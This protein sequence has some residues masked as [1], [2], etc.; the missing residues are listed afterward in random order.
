ML[1]EKSS[2]CKP[3]TVFYANAICK[4][5]SK[6]AQSHDKVELIL[7]QGARIQR[8]REAVKTFSG[9]VSVCAHLCPSL[10]GAS[11]HELAIKSNLSA[12]KPD[13]A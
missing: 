10:G 4:L 11:L 7:T 13:V 1:T 3:R 6:T 9:K 5:R 12:R 2:I 8:S